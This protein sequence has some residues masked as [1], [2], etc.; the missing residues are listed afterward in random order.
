MRVCDGSEGDFVYFGIE[1]Q[2]R[3]NVKIQQHDT[4][5][6]ELVFNIDGISP[7]KSSSITIWPILGKVYTELDLYDPF[8]I[9]IYCGN[10]KLMTCIE[11]LKIFI[12]E[13]NQLLANGLVIQ[14]KTQC[15]YC[16]WDVQKDC[17][18][19]YYNLLLTRLEWV[20]RK[21]R[22]WSGEVN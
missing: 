1:N 14:E 8:T 20:Q 10:G 2:L 12:M 13:L 7:F 3:K 21:E 9:A 6:L 4:D 5:T 19:S 11:Y 22:N 17:W 16:I 18:N 15:T